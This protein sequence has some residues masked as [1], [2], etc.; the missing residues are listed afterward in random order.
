MKDLTW[1][2]ETKLAHR[3]LHE[4]DL[5]IPENSMEAF[6]NAM[7][8]GYGL[9]LDL[10]LLKDNTI[11]VFHDHH[12]KR[13]TG[14][15]KD[16]G[17]C[18]YDDIKS[19]TL[20]DTDSHIPTFDELLRFVDGRVPLL[21]EIKPFGDIENFCSL[22]YQRLKVYQGTYA[23][24]SFH[25]KVIKWFKQN[26]PE[27]IRGQIATKYHKSEAVNPLIGALLARLFFNRFTKPDFISYNVKHMPNKHLDKAKKR[28]VTIISYVARDQ[29]TF[30][31][32]K[33]HYDNIVFEFFTPE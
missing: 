23:I 31:F 11:I 1:L 8:H 20:H 30:D 24:F 6:E 21:I 16:V 27:V 28:G 14:L 9:E 7:S 12:L 3:G 4:K 17:S 2:K 33:K 19:L 5:S 29:K 32:V 18:T 26:A 15:D 10:N 22:V 25:P 13:M